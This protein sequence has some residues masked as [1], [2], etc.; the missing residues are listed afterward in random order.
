MTVKRGPLHE[1]EG[2]TKRHTDQAAILTSPKGIKLTS[3]HL[4]TVAQV[5]SSTY[6][7]K[8]KENFGKPFSEILVFIPEEWLEKKLSPVEKGN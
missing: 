7:E 3:K 2:D 1:I 6:D 4:K 5:I 8:C